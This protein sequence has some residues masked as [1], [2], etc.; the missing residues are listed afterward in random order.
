MV[1]IY[2]LVTGALMAAIGIGAGAFGAHALKDRLSMSD[3]VIYET[4]MRYWMYHALGLC[5]VSLVMTRI[6]NVFMK[7]S[8]GSMFIG[9]VIFSGTLVALVLTGNRMLGAVTP[10]GGVLL[11]VGWVSLAAGVLMH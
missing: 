2:V 8:V 11:I 5:L 3:L 10:I 6:E 9:A 7:V 1:W 4:A